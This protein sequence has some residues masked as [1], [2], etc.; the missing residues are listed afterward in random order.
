MGPRW[1]GCYRTATW[2]SPLLRG[3]IRLSW[4]TSD[5]SVFSELHPECRR[6]WVND[7]VGYL[8]GHPED[9][10]VL[11]TRS[12]VIRDRRGDVAG[13][14]DPPDPLAGAALFV[15]MSRYAHNQLSG[16]SE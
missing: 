4:V 10:V 14:V 3:W 2:R 1:G 5:G 9:P 11:V 12:G 8:A 6:G 16:T 13:T 7:G 15:A